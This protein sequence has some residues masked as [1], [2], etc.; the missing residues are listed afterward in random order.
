LRCPGD[1]ITEEQQART[2]IT[3]KFWRY[4]KSKKQESSGVAT[5]EVDGCYMEDNKSKAEALSKQFQSVFTDEDMS[6]LPQMETSK[7]QGLPDVLALLY[8][9]C[10]A[11]IDLLILL[12][13]QGMFHLLVQFFC[14]I[15]C[16]MRNI[17]MSLNDSQ[18]LSIPFS[19]FSII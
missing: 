3:K 12:L 16:V 13:I 4:I 14:G 18:Q 11:R 9:L 1:D 2:S 17:S 19:L 15:F 7:T 5:L 8:C 10:L 6:T